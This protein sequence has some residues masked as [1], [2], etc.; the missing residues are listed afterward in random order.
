MGERA[1]DERETME[2]QKGIELM[3]IGPLEMT[4][5]SNLHSQFQQIREEGQGTRDGSAGA[6]T[7]M[8]LM[9]KRW[10]GQRIAADQAMPGRARASAEVLYRLW[11]GLLLRCA[12]AQLA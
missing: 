12:A 7:G 11:A 4:M 5:K 9:Q 6:W 8:R 10:T 1:G 2:H 3:E